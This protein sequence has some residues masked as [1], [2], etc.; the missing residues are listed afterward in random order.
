MRK[1]CPQRVLHR[2]GVS[3]A[4]LGDRP[5]SP[6]VGKA[7][8]KGL[9]LVAHTSAV[10]AENTPAGWPAASVTVTSISRPESRCAAGVRVSI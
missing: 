10:P 9:T 4:R 6:C 1:Q 2:D 7:R 5:V 3:W 8:L